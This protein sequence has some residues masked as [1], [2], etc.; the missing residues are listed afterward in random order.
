VRIEV[1]VFSDVELR[2][3]HEKAASAGGYCGII[4]Y[5]DMQIMPRYEV[6]VRGPSGQAGRG[7]AWLPVRRR[8][9]ALPRMRARRRLGPAARRLERL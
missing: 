8:G 5:A 7:H 6:G 1:M 9:Y 3:Q 4:G 2:K